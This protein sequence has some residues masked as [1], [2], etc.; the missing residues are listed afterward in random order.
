VLVGWDVFPDEDGDGVGAG[1]REAVCA[2]RTVPTGYSTSGTDCATTDAGR[3]RMMSYQ[4]RDAD[5]DSYTVPETGSVC[6]GQTLPAGYATV[7]KGPDCDDARAAVYVGFNAYEDSDGD[8]VGAGSAVALCTDGSV[9]TP[10]S[11]SGTDC[12]PADERQWQRMAYAHV[13]RD[14]DGHTTPSSGE[15]CV[16][17]ALPSGY[18]AT[19]LGND[20]DDAAPA[21]FRWVVLYADRD[22]DAVG[23]GARSV[24]CLGAAL[25]SGF[26]R[27]G[28][29]VDD[30][31]PALREDSEEDEVT[32][33]VLGL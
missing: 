20:C 24:P 12:A 6:G 16:G 14:G 9:P 15:L 13:D 4:H 21:L 27:L 28:F 1:T 30:A 18:S 22:G 10:Y 3:W 29:D 31:D 26:S 19:A 2:G 17:K 23:A 7:Q 11:R 5:V 33:L 8:G 25:P 32:E